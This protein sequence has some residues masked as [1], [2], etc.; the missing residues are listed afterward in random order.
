[1]DFTRRRKD[2]GLPHSFLPDLRN[3]PAWPLSGLD[4]G[5]PVFAARS[6]ASDA[7][8]RPLPA[9]SNQHTSVDK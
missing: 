9:V 8:A 1:M 6:G 7:Q 3:G 4:Q 2:S 5:V